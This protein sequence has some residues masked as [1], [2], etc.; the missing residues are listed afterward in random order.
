[1]FPRRP[2]ISA[3]LGKI[4]FDSHLLAFSLTYL[5]FSIETN[6]LYKLYKLF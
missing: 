2:R 3:G 1:M 5:G 6:I 4:I